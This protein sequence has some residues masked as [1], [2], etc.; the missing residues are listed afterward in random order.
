MCVIIGCRDSGKRPSIEILRAAERA[1]RDGAGVAF[2]NKD[3]HQVNFVKGLDADGVHELCKKHK[4]G[5]MVIHFRFAT[6]GGKVAELCHPFPVAQ[7]TTLATVGTVK[8][9]LFHNGH[10]GGWQEKCL[11]ASIETKADVPAGHFSDSRGIAWLC[12]IYGMR[13]LNFIPGKF[14]VLDQ[15]GMRVYG[16]GWFKINGLVYSNTHW[17]PFQSSGQ[18]NFGSGK[19]GGK[20]ESSC[21]FNQ[22]ALPSAYRDGIPTYGGDR[23]ENP[24]ACGGD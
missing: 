5:P 12:S 17:M 13:I 23:M 1:N 3:G 15:G 22:R 16:E 19:S 6:V 11:E 2:M 21:G 24:M 18:T 9:V 4:D 7:D 8:R 20:S 14:A 10:W